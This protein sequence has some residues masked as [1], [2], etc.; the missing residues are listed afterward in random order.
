MFNWQEGTCIWLLDFVSDAS[1]LGRSWHWLMG[2]FLAK[3]WDSSF[4]SVLSLLFTHCPPPETFHW[5]QARLPG[6]LETTEWVAF[7]HLLCCLRPLSPP[8]RKGLCYFHMTQCCGPL[9]EKALSEK[10]SFRHTYMLVLWD[11]SNFGKTEAGA[12]N[13]VVEPFRSWSWGVPF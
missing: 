8:N 6:C 3:E 7:P 13:W 10:E 9:K 11:L 5:D 4:I 2:H 12:G 1:P